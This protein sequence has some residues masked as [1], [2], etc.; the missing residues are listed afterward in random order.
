M[1][2]LTGHLHDSSK[3]EEDLRRESGLPLLS[4]SQLPERRGMALAMAC[5]WEPLR[6]RDVI[7]VIEGY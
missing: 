1:E 5:A 2:V 6:T 3:Q 4:A 7:D